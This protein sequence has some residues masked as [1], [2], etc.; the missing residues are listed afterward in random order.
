MALSG[1]PVLHIFGQSPGVHDG[2][3]LTSQLQVVPFH[4]ALS[5]HAVSQLP[6]QLPGVHWFAWQVQ[7]D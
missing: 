1:H 5:G 3:S 7:I 2:F 4:I 6:G